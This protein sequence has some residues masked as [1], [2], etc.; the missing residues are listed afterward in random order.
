[1]TD[2]TNDNYVIGLPDY[3]IDCCLTMKY[4]SL[5]FVR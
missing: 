4:Y 1:M 3:D 5:R 2:E